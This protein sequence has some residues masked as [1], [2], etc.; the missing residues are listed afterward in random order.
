M[1]LF[2]LQ[3]HFLMCYCSSLFFHWAFTHIFLLIQ[4]YL[5]IIFA[6]VPEAIHSSA[7]L[8]DYLRNLRIMYIFLQ[9]H[10]TGSQYRLEK[11]KENTI[12]RSWTQSISIRIHRVQNSQKKNPQNITFSFKHP[13][14]NQFL[15]LEPL[16]TYSWSRIPTLWK[17]AQV[18]LRKN[19]YQ[20][21][22]DHFPDEDSH[23]KMLPSKLAVVHPYSH[24]YKL[25]VYIW[26]HNNVYGPNKSKTLPVE[27]R[28]LKLSMVFK[29]HFQFHLYLWDIHWAHPRRKQRNRVY[30]TFF[31][32]IVQY[33]YHQQRPQSPSNLSDHTS[34][35]T[36]QI[37]RRIRRCTTVSYT[38]LT[39]PTIYSV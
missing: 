35:M 39:L 34:I 14:W 31:L 6:C 2:S 20:R 13:P 19:L 32:C 24:I 25:Q 12:T 1:A 9:V 26:P 16:S 22:E 5:I 36:K 33:F 21:S 10:P 17:L 38:H 37:F 27:H 7:Y 18:E 4:L 30:E 29:L 11:S 8:Y 3:F 23:D 28:L 15:N